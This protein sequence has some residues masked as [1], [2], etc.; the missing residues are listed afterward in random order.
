MLC[1]GLFRNKP[2]PEGMAWCLCI[3]AHMHGWQNRPYPSGGSQY[4]L[5]IRHTHWPSRRG[6]GLSNQYCPCTRNSPE[7]L[8]IPSQAGHGYSRRSRRRTAQRRQSLCM[9]CRKAGMGRLKKASLPLCSRQPPAC[10]RS[11]RWMIFL[12]QVCLLNTI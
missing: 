11:R 4:C 2:D 12:P 8:Q 6:L 9:L 3:Q 5:C 1:S 7:S 10:T